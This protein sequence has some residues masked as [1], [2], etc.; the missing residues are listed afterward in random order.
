ME[1][2]DLAKSVKGKKITAEQGNAIAGALRQANNAL[3]FP[4]EKANIKMKIERHNKTFDS[5]IQI[6]E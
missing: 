4:H 1:S 5:N 3:R 2:L 6:D